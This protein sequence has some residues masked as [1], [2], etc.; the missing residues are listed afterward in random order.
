MAGRV[1]SS[2]GRGG[3]DIEPW[4]PPAGFAA[5][6]D[7][8]PLLDKQ[9]AKYEDYRKEL[10]KALPAWDAWLHPR[11]KKDVGARLALWARAKIYGEKGLVYS[12]PLYRSMTV[13]ADKAR[14][15][16]EHVGGGTVPHRPLVT[17][18]G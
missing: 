11:N 4:T 8:K 6:P 9:A 2:Q 14:I 13:E 12:G 18:S 15:A 1:R 5:V 16:L 10:E 7:T 3:T 17:S